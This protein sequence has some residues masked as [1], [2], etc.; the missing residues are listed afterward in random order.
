MI[1]LLHPRAASPRS[2]RFPLSMLALAAVID[3][4]EEY[5]I[6]DGNVD[7]DA[8]GTLQRLH[9]QTPLELLA[10]SVMPG[11][12]MVAA[13]PLCR[14]FRRKWPAVPIVW[15]GYFPSLY[16]DAALNADY[17]DFAVRAQG[18]ETFTD[19]IAA[20]RGNRDFSAIRGLSYKDG[21]GR[22][23]HNPDRALR[24]PD[25]FPWYPYHRLDASKYILPT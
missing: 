20:L 1:I 8:G 10:V 17:V 21:A 19:L 6:I 9:L 5:A 24:G 13:I 22:H 7:T 25:D 16:P 18:E 3:G 14:S 4:K 15:G 2:R 11:P 23:V 12:Q